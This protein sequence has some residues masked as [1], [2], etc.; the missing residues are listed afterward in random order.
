M[1][2]NYRFLYFAPLLICI[3]FNGCSVD[4]S[5]QETQPAIRDL[6]ESFDPSWL[7]SDRERF[8]FHDFLNKKHHLGSGWEFDENQAETRFPWPRFT[9]ASGIIVLDWNHRMERRI[10]LKLLNIASDYPPDIIGLSVNGQ[11]V[12]L[13]EDHLPCGEY[14]FYVPSSVQKTGINELH[15]SL[16]R[17]RLPP[18]FD[19][20]SIGLHSIRI[21]LGAVVRNSIQIGDQVRSSLLFAPPVGLRIPYQSAKK[22]NLQFSYGLFSSNENKNKF[23][24]SLE[25]AIFEKNG[26]RPVLERRFPI[27][28]NQETCSNWQ[29][30]KQKL[31]VMADQGILEITFSADEEITGPIDYLALSE[32]LIVPAN[33][34]GDHDT[35]LI[36][37]DIILTTLS[38]VAARQLGSYGNACARTPFLDR[39]SQ[40]GLIFIDVTSASNGEVPSL[41]SIAT[42]KLPRDHG[43]YRTNSITKDFPYIF[44]DLLT[45]TDY[46]SHAFAFTNSATQSVLSRLPGFKRVYFSNPSKDSLQSIRAQLNSML[47][48]PHIIAQPGF[49]WFHFAPE[50]VTPGMI[51]GMFDLT[52]YN[53]NHLPISDLNIPLSEQD[54]LFS[55]SQKIN[56]NGDVRSLLGSNDYRL[57]NLD[58]TV[59]SVV[60]DIIDQ[61]SSRDVSMI[62]TS[63][64]GIIR[65]LNSNVLSNDSLSQE[66][67]HVPLIWNEIRSNSDQT[68]YRKGIVSTAIS[69]LK[70]CEMMGK[71]MR[72]GDLKSISWNGSPG[73]TIRPII[74][75]HDTRP[76]IAYRKEEFKMIH[77]LSN[78]YY[79][80]ATTNLFNLD[81]DPG[82]SINLAGRDP[83]YTQQFL[84]PVLAFCRGSS[85]YPSPRMGL[86]EE[87]QAILQSL[88]Y[89]VQ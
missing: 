76:I 58:K 35:N 31:P 72:N 21:T 19:I 73:S 55:L 60:R 10:T 5:G 81:T 39:F 46:Q 16:N 29:F 41:L 13:M 20:H 78:P 11:A 4:Q 14:E 87:T 89:T 88:K 22:Q 52:V 61:R 77:C 12:P 59:S 26:D 56:A 50:T 65:S 7:N 1:R 40:H 43:A 63:D 30:V 51:D 47:T 84:D 74:A 23:V 86:E 64:S 8:V 34:K 54:R 66:V 85:F 36:Q 71:L 32:I 75:E 15:V 53:K 33:Q 28:R 70:I 2:S 48:S 6:V 79:Q 68:E 3:I 57:T 69:N 17:D 82:E 18:D 45:E 42:G 83:E 80:I 9:M 27:I 67:L 38:S 44:G 25:V 37:P 62:V 24:Y 49:F